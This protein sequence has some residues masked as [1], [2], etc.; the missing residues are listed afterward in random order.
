VSHPLRMALAPVL[1][2]GLAACGADRPTA[3]EAAEAPV[4]ALAVQ[5][6]ALAAIQAVVIDADERLLSGLDAGAKSRLGT[7]L[8]AVRT[9]LDANDAEAMQ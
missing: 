8:A 2:L 6:E 5:G 9:A 7:A 4:T 3:P 1:A